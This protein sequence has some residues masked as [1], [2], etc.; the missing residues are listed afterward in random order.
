MPSI[1]NS[2][3]A[4]DHDVFD[5]IA[6]ACKYKCVEQKVLALVDQDRCVAIEHHQIGALADS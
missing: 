3:A 2:P 1:N 5:G 6:V 4:T